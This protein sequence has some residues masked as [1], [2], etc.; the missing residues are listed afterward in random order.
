MERRWDK[1]TNK[2]RT[3][4]VGDLTLALQ[5]LV[6]DKSL[7]DAGKA[8]LGLA[9]LNDTMPACLEGVRLALL[10]RLDGYADLALVVPSDIMRFFTGRHVMSFPSVIVEDCGDFMFFAKNRYGANG[11]VPSLE[12]DIVLSDDPR[13]VARFTFPGKKA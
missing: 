5:R 13:I 2:A 1:E 7:S 12:G 9:A 11:R 4:A 8:G 6:L 3:G 10:E